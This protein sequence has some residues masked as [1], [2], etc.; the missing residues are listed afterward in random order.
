MYDFF[1]FLNISLSLCLINC[2]DSINLRSAGISFQVEGN[3]IGGKRFK[4]YSCDE[5]RNMQLCF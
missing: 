5:E 2:L 3:D 4:K 1:F